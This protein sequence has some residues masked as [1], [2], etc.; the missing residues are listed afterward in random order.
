M[1]ISFT[2]LGCPGWDLDTICSQGHE[3]GYDG[4]DFRGYLDTLD[5]TSLPL[6]TTE[7][8]S[9]R[10]QIED[11]GLVVS[12][13]SSSITVCLP[14]KMEQNLEEAR[15][16]IAVAIAWVRNIFASLAMVIQ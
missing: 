15:R 12:G 14:E 9:T 2:T 1:K 16:T 8:K 4:V 11:A 7:A 10:Q 6:F 3:L 5:I 13:I